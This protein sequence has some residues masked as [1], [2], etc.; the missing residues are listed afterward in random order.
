MIER[1]DNMMVRAVMDA[2]IEEGPSRDRDHGALA[3]K[4]GESPESYPPPFPV[5]LTVDPIQHDTD[6]KPLYYWIRKEAYDAHWA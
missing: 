4:P 5:V 3:V 6:G 2:L 1:A